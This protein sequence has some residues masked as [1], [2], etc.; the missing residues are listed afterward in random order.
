MVKDI[1][2][3]M[4]ESGES[5]RSWQ[6][7]VVED[8]SAAYLVQVQSLVDTAKQ[9]DSVFSKRSK[10]ASA[11]ISTAGPTK[12]TSSIS[13]SEKIALQMIFDIRAFATEIQ[14]VGIQEPTSAAPS[15]ALMCA[16]ITEMKSS[17]PN[18]SEK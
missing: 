12:S 11:G 14:S 5:A 4:I 9:M 7:D 18:I 15:Y 16:Q 17:F 3:N 2:S 1:R 13:D 8:I 10:P 6:A